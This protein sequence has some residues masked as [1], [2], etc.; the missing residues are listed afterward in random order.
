MLI[1]YISDLKGWGGGGSRQDEGVGGK[2][3]STMIK[4]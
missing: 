2:E 3:V 1:V 4:V